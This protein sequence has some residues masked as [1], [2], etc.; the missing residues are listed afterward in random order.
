MVGWRFV[1][2][3]K[4]KPIS[5]GRRKPVPVLMKNRKLDARF[6]AKCFQEFAESNASAPTVQLQIIRLCLSLIAYR[7]WNFRVSDVSRAIPRSEH[8][9][10]EAY[11]KLPEGVEKG[12]SARKLLKPL[13]GLST[14]C[15]DWYRTIRDL[16][17]NEC[18]W[19]GK[20]RP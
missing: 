4:N 20:L 6:R 8:L 17:A 5:A 13:Y 18:V 3:V 7:K 2:T 16:L 12:N 14:A 19:G 1:Y 11:V 10:R 15:K 9:K